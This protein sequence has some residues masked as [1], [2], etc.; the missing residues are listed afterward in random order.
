MNR[1]LRRLTVVLGIGA[2]IGIAAPIAAT[3]GAPL[4]GVDVKLGKNPGGKPAARTVKSSKSNTSDRKSS[5]V[6]ANKKGNQ[7]GNQ[8]GSAGIAVSDPGAEG[9]KPNKGN[10]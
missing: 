4:K 1:A 2:M 10:K 5:S 7:S 8:S 6:I 3:A 9:S